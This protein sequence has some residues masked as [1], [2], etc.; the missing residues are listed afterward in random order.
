MLGDDIE[1]T[2]LSTHGEKVRLGIQAP[3]D[4]PVYRIEIYREIQQERRERGD[5]EGAGS[6]L[7]DPVRHLDGPRE[8]G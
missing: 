3:S 1:V 5:R 2:V 8:R 6:E 4:V 7:D